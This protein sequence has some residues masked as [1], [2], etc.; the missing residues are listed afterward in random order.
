[1]EGEAPERG[2][3]CSLGDCEANALNV[4]G[5][6]FRQAAERHYDRSEDCSFTTFVGYE[7]TQ[8]QEMAN[9]HRN[10][11]FKGE[12]VTR[13]PISVFDTDSSVP[14]YGAA[15]IPMSRVGFWIAMS[16]P[17]LTTPIWAAD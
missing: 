4:P 12:Q 8:G 1:M 16:W 10:V 7:Y 14:S 9:L 15:P 5:T 6:T 11:I 17:Y 3:V 13:L 2:M